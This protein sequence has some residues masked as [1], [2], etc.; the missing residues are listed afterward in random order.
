MSIIS[1]TYN[2]ESSTLHLELVEKKIVIGL[3]ITNE[4]KRELALLFE[5]LVANMETNTPFKSTDMDLFNVDFV[6]KTE[7]T[8]GKLFYSCNKSGRTSV[9]GELLNSYALVDDLDA[10]ATVLKNI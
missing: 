10:L 2:D 7:F 4:E 3:T 8:S 9:S 5:T 6:Q 1:F